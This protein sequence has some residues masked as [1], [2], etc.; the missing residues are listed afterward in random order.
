MFDVTVQPKINNS[1][2][3]FKNYK[4]IAHIYFHNRL[5]TRKKSYSGN[6]G[7]SQKCA[8]CNKSK[9]EVKFT[10]DCH[11]IPTS[12]GNTI[13]LTHEECNTCNS[14]HGTTIEDALANMFI[15]NRIIGHVKGRKYP[16]ITSTNGDRFGISSTTG[17]IEL[18]TKENGDIKVNRG[19]KDISFQVPIAKYKPYDALRGI[20]KSAWFH[21]PMEERKHLPE[22][23]S[24]IL[25]QSKD[26]IDA[27]FATLPGNGYEHT[28]LQIFKSKKSI[29]NKHSYL[30]IFKFVNTIV[31]WFSNKDQ[32]K[33]SFP[34]F[35]YKHHENEGQI[36][37]VLY[38]LKRENIWGGEQELS[39][40][41]KEIKPILTQAD[42]P[43][44]QKPKKLNNREFK[45]KYLD[46]Q[47][48]VKVKLNRWD[49]EV[50]DVEIFGGDL[51]AEIK[52]F[53]NIVTKFEYYS[54][55][56]NFPSVPV[57]KLEHTFHL[58]DALVN[59]PCKL[60]FYYEDKSLFI[61]KTKDV[62]IHTNIE[63]ARKTSK[64]LITIN[65]EFNLN[66]RYPAKVVNR[67]FEEI[68]T[69]GNAIRLGEFSF[70]HK[71]PKQFIIRSTNANAFDK[72]LPTKA[73]ISV[74]FTV[75]YKFLGKSF[76]P[77]TGTLKMG[78]LKFMSKSEEKG[79][80]KYIFEYKIES[81]K[82]PEFLNKL[83]KI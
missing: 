80:Y 9:P 56:L 6:K 82:F 73:E 39:F 30:V 63:S 62:K 26:P 16:K 8:L 2:D 74:D 70:S 38:N 21:L 48:S 50:W 32:K 68:E 72:P 66:L 54:L 23:L 31:F 83:G 76:G 71:R 22:L 5:E 1:Q 59:S 61:L 28:T 44:I 64:D 37:L 20:L 57:E 17:G 46:K 11:T 40:N 42:V 36:K 25:N 12:L 14:T 43:L 75:N 33:H 24:Y 77:F 49:K 65:K 41:F 13:F 7:V 47:L 78:D 67:E 58:L 18:I 19:K 34:T 60:E 45:L 52:Y 55:N 69:L 3:F 27:Y 79:K 29:N 53:K 4:E 35:I 15:T 51:G 81:Y 10:Q